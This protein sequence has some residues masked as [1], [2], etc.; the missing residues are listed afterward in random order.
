MK[1][2]ISR[3]DAIIS[4]EAVPPSPHTAAPSR[5]PNIKLEPD[6]K[7][8]SIC[9]L[10][11]D[12]GC[13][14]AK[15]LSIGYF[16][17]ND[18]ME[19]TKEGTLRKNTASKIPDNFF[20]TN[21]SIQAIVGVNGSG[22]SSILEMIYRLI[23][24]FSFMLELGMHK[25]NGAMKLCYVK[26]LR[27][28]LFFLIDG[29]VGILSSHDDE[30]KFEFEEYEQTLSFHHI[31][32]LGLQ[33][34]YFDVLNIKDEVVEEATV[35]APVARMADVASRF[36]YTIVSNYSFQSY[37][38]DDYKDERTYIEYHPELEEG[39]EGKKQVSRKVVERDEGDVWI[40]NVFHKNDG[41]R[42]PIVL[43][44]YRDEGYIDLNKEYRLSLYR[45]TAIF[46]RAQQ[47]KIEVL[48][49][50][51]LGRIHYSFDSLAIERKFQQLLGGRVRHDSEWIK[52]L[53][54][55][56]EILTRPNTYIY[57]I[58]RTLGLLEMD[59]S[60]QIVR[61][62]CLYMA[63]KVWAIA[64]KYP[65]Y[66]EYEDFSNAESY[67]QEVD[68]ERTAERLTALVEKVRKDS[69]HI[70][71]KFR[72]MEAF[73]RLLE[74]KPDLADQWAMGF[75]YYQ[76]ITFLESEGIINHQP[77]N[78]R[79]LM[80]TL[81]PA[82]YES[83][84]CLLN[85]RGKE[86]CIRRMSSGE[87]Q[88]LYT[89]S[90][91][92]YHIFN[93]MSVSER[94]RVRYRCM[95]LVLDEVEICFHPEYQRKFISKLIGLLT[96]LRLNN[97]CSINIILATHSPFILSDIPQQNIL[98]LEDGKCVN[99]QITINPYAA[100]VNDILIQSFFLK[101]SFMGD[102][103]KD[104]IRK[105]IVDIEKIGKKTRSI[106]NILAEVNLIGD[107]FLKQQL[108]TLVEYRKSLMLYEQDNNR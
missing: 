86:M 96:K 90:T 63:Y 91:F 27:L 8:F 98:Y 23:N 32:G 17:F 85:S 55:Q 105:L 67:F 65:S 100:N 72:Q 99:E 49:E 102:F 42:T 60:K 74:K 29:K 107:A 54:I 46:L 22:K 88:F 71:F 56:A 45:L 82:I 34:V 76:Y 15:N 106:E 93:L 58:L 39:K 19:L 41:Y 11:I 94:K 47:Q 101:E 92:V 5:T 52:V 10:R 79:E 30:M 25:S 12:E 81:P 9:A 108:M 40:H 50:Y 77:H 36:F 3:R 97:R 83:D 6:P 57:I 73:L 20:G 51:R 4:I 80:L 87:R 37:I 48:D 69:S 26:G 95:N 78:M 68:D 89:C 1:Q 14:C 62:A 70:T 66:Y 103:A 84:I 31:D 7:G 24:N 38:D 104:R 28:S 18:K 33:R 16:L 61:D 44:P 2:R 59:F 53:D 64:A 43:N 75:D 13:S 35:K 21:I